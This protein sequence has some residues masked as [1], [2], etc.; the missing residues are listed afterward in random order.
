[1]ALITDSGTPAVADPGVSAVRTARSV[2]AEVSIVP[3][4]SAV[5]AALAASGFGADRFV[6]EGFLPR[7]GRARSER[8]AAIATEE[9]S[10]VFFSVPHRLIE[11]LSD[12]ANL[13]S[14]DRELCVG[15][16]LTKRFEEVWWGTVTEAAAHFGEQGPRGEFTVVVEGTSAPIPDVDDAVDLARSLA[17]EGM[18]RSE[19]AR[20]AAHRTGVRR[21][22]IYDRM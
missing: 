13:C 3:G 17:Q 18:T 14:P 4:P 9:R 16:E 15:R 20:E 1:M 21:R 10:V 19:A 11:D 8:L 22:E 5:T 6:F 7:K 2:G 12:L